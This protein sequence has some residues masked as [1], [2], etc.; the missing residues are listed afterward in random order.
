MSKAGG[1]SSCAQTFFLEDTLADTFNL[2]GA[3][4]DAGDDVACDLPSDD[5]FP[6]DMTSF[7]GGDSGD[8][9]PADG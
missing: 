2:Y 1:W 9:D 4:S 5:D 6:L 7:G 3:D 8:S